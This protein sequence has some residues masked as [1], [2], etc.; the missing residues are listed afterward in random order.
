M[1]VSPQN[2]SHINPSQD[3][4]PYVAQP[5]NSEMGQNSKI[6]QNES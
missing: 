6:S 1:M 3:R 5:A 4:P 2:T